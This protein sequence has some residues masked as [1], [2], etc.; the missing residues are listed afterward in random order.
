M[1]PITDF[2]S[3]Q[4]A[5]LDKETLIAII[6]ELREIVIKQTVQIQELQDQLAKSSKNSGKPPSSDGLK[7]PRT[8]S[9]RR[10][11][12]RQSGGQKGHK[13]HTLE[14]VEQP[15]QAVTHSVESCP[16]C[17]ADLHAVAPDMI[18]KRQVFA[19][20]PVRV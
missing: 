9:L 6:L 5:D 4:L 7:K 11:K 20:P 14:M 16:H 17:A 13:G 3:E 19:I 12:G 15:D 1:T 18:E 2:T 8:R 10:K